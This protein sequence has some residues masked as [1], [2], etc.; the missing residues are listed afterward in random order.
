M[1]QNEDRWGRSPRAR[2]RALLGR[3]PIRREWP[4]RGRAS[5]GRAVAGAQVGGLAWPR[6]PGPGP[7]S[8]LPNQ[9]KCLMKW[10]GRRG[11]PGRRCRRPR[12][13]PCGVCSSDEA[14]WAGRLSRL[15][16][17][18][19]PLGPAHGALRARPSRRNGATGGHAAR[20]AQG[21][22]RGAAG[23]GRGVMLA[24]PPPRPAAPHGGAPAGAGA[25][26]RQ[27]RGRRPPARRGGWPR[28][29]WGRRASSN[30]LPR[31][32]PRNLKARARAGCRGPLYAGRLR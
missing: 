24:T 28:G 30:A 22:A 23:Q 18:V 4:Y 9:T 25:D 27:A 31:P 32:A 21:R 16:H 1:R 29:R 3:V 26:G 6:R 20:P 5:R 8:S 10:G 19:Q 17:R 12:A 15:H 13:G 2:A 7:R 11:P 14:P